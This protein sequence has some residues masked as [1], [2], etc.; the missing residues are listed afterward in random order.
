MVDSETT[1]T[2]RTVWEGSTRILF[3]QFTGLVSARDAS[4]WSRGLWQTLDR[5]PDHTQF[6]L[7]L[8][9]RGI[10]P[11]DI[12][13]HQAMRKVIPEVLARH[14]LRPAFIDL[15]DEKPEMTINVSRGVRCVAFANVHHEKEKMDAY[16]ARIGRDN[17]QFFSDLES[18]KKWLSA[19]SW[20]MP[21][22]EG[23]RRI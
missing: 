12:P 1:K 20:R 19:L 9:L 6:K 15:F 18:A 23:G 13:A 7:L 2:I 8:H 5:L 4:E 17:Q 10:D 14:G 22:V 3:T 16:R 11:K 21:Y